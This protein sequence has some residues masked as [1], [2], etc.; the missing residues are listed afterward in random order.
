MDDPFPS[1]LILAEI[2]QVSAGFWLIN[3][4]I[5]MALLFFS[6]LISGSEVAFFSL[7]PED[8]RDLQA[9]K[10]EKSQLIIKLVE[11]PQKLLSTILILNN[12]LN[13]S[14]ITFTT[15]ITWSIFGSDDIGITIVLAQIAI[16][17]FFLIFFQYQWLCQRT[18][19]G[20]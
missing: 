5:F 1:I 2:I 10:D 7:T 11:A 12:L 6:A 17:S 3:G 8:L 19:L 13:I 15:V 9:N 14:I 20:L 18:C 4:L 16:V